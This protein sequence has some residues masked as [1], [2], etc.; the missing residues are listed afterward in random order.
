MRILVINYE[1]PPIGGGGGFVT[2]DICENIVSRGH[3]V[4]VITSH[5]RGLLKQETVNGVKVIRVPV[6]SRNK[7]EV[8]NIGS[9]ASYFPISILSAMK[10]IKPNDYEIINTHFA[11]PSGPTGYVLSK[12]L[13]LPNVLSIHGGDIFD[14]SKSL[15]PHDMP[16]LKQTVRTMLNTADRVVAQSSDTKKNA[17][18]Y[19]KIKRPIDIIPLGI[20]QHDFTKKS[21]ADFNFD[22][23]EIIFCTIGRLIKRKNINDTIAVLSELKNRYRFKFLIIGDGPERGN[24]DELAKQHGLGSNVQLMGNVSDEL[25]FQLLSLSDIFL[26]TALHE[27]FGLVFLEAMEAGIPVVCYNRG[28][29]NDFLEDGKTGFLVK[30]GDKKKFKARVLEIISNNALRSIMSAYNK[31]AIKKFYIEVCAEKYI[32]L[33]DK[34][35]S[36]HSI[37]GKNI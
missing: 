15:S 7:M 35:I 12:L 13:R 10:N 27:G 32:S 16:V 14:P 17:Y 6:Y 3:V 5:Y 25:K 4:T 11:I 1:Y 20:K 29:Q 26:S 22:P 19:Y 18:Q 28:G 33:F 8:A 24:I 31:K 34:V 36:D 9:M 23:D 21:R 30:L 37:S 2:R